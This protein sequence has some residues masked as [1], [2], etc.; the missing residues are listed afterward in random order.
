[1]QVE[2][3]GT[4]Y[5]SWLN[6]LFYPGRRSFVRVVFSTASSDKRAVCGRVLSNFPGFATLRYNACTVL[7]LLVLPVQCIVFLFEGR[8]RGPVRRHFWRA[9]D[10]ILHF[11]HF[12]YVK[13]PLF[14]LQY[15]GFYCK[16]EHWESRTA[17]CL[18]SIQDQSD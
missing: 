15:E 18:L 6:D 12:S 4:L 5:L 16:R 10:I 8:E 14:Q 3:S 13:D 1:M 11:A 7:K 2:V 9:V 17:L